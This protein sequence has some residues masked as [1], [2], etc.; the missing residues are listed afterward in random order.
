[1]VFSLPGG[2]GEDLVGGLD[3][4]EGVGT[5]VPLAG[6]GIDRLHHGAHGVERAAPQGLP[7]EDAE[8]DLDLVQPGGAGRGEVEVE[9]LVPREPRFTAGVL[10]VETLSRIRCTS[11]S[12]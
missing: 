8:P 11:P 9:A 1:M 12:G 6:E 2:F 4:H 3:T 10:W 5:V 7:G